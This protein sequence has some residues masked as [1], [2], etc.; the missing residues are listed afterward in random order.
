MPVSTLGGED[1]PSGGSD[2]P[3]VRKRCLDHRAE[4]RPCGIRD[5]TITDGSNASDGV[6]Q[7][8]GMLSELLAGSNEA[9]PIVCVPADTTQCLAEHPS[10]ILDEAG[11]PKNAVVV[12]IRPLFHVASAQA[13]QFT[14]ECSFGERAWTRL[15]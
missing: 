7:P 10:I 14:R 1:V 5:L 3:H 2:A 15:R 9:R 4:G 8:E 6:V 13:P 12:Q 11:A